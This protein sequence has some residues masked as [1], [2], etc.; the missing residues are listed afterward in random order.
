VE[1][2]GR[3]RGIG[4]DEVAELDGFDD[5]AVAS[6]IRLGHVK[7][8]SK[9]SRGHSDFDGFCLS[10]RQNEERQARCSQQP[11]QHV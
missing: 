3:K 8:F 10:P 1:I 5:E 4:S 6:C 9:R 11:F 7:D 2:A